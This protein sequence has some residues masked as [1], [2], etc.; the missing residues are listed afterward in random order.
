MLQA[1]LRYIDFYKKC[2]QYWQKINK[3]P[4]FTDDIMKKN[5]T[6]YACGMPS[7]SESQYTRGFTCP[8]ARDKLSILEYVEPNNMDWFV[9][10]WCIGQCHNRALA[11][12]Q[13]LQ[14]ISLV[15][16]NKQWNQMEHWKKTLFS[17]Q[18]LDFTTYHLHLAWCDISERKWRRG[19]IADVYDENGC[20]LQI[21]PD[22]D[23]LKY[24]NLIYT[25]DIRK[26]NL[27]EYFLFQRPSTSRSPLYTKLPQ[28]EY[29]PDFIHENQ[30][31]IDTTNPQNK[32]KFNGQV[33]IA[34]NS[35]MLKNQVTVR[36]VKNGQLVD[37]SLDLIKRHQQTF[38]FFKKF[39]WFS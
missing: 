13:E 34:P 24:E 8:Y 32:Q 3:N 22:E 16:R 30:V 19:S 14:K 29:G 20:T 6:C 10:E 5:I 28:Y 7:Y 21:F 2:L 37:V 15:Y 1:D 9:C 33:M 27:N 25:G 12:F 35:R 38:E 11:R 39:E 31:I 26:L 4:F 17:L 23:D 18:H 36:I